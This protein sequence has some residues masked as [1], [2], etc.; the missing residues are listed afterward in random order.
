MS[1]FDKNKFKKQFV[2]GGIYIALA[3][4]VVTVTLNGV[5][6]IIGGNDIDKIPDISE[7]KLPDI[8]EDKTKFPQLLD[9]QLTDEADIPNTSVSGTKEGV[10]AESQDNEDSDKKEDVPKIEESEKE[11]ES[12]VIVMPVDGYIDRE[13]SL[14]KLLYS[15]TMSDYRTHNGIDICADVGTS[16]RAMAGGTVEQ[17]YFD[18]MYGYTVVINHGENTLGYYMNL[19][20]AIPK[21]IVVGTSVDAGTTIGG[22]GQSAVCESADVSHL[23]FSVTRDG[24]F[25]DPCDILRG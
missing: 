3:A 1:N 24:K 19:S 20:E 18:D 7:I 2:S 15:P 6:K 5:N 14:D 16:V 10:S 9:V 22:I 25:I 13:F 8:V 23:H 11:A 21:N 17:V 4:A 12:A